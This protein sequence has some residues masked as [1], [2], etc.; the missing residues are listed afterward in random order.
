MI[1][2][3][4]L[5][6]KILLYTKNTKETEKQSICLACSYTEKIY[7]LITIAKINFCI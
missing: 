5:K 1:K 6:T 2:T 7:Y 3:E 4:L